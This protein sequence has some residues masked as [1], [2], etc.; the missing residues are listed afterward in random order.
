MDRSELVSQLLRADLAVT[1]GERLLDLQ[2]DVLQS[3]QASRHDTSLAEFILTRLKREQAM[4]LS[5]RE[6]VRAELDEPG[7]GSRQLQ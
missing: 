6:Q 1:E 4:L 3:L 7:P 2:E 5:A